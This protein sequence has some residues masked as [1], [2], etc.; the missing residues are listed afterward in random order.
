VVTEAPAVTTYTGAAY[1]LTV[2]YPAGWQQVAGD[3]SPSF[4]GTDGFFTIGG[5][6][7]ADSVDDVCRAQAADSLQPFGTAPTIEALTVDGQE[8]CLIL[9]SADQ[10]AEARGAARLVA[11]LPYELFSVGYNFLVLDADATHIRPIAAS[12][13]F[14]GHD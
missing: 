5:T 12:L 14:L 1:P 2:D 9:P 6:A 10:P 3:P 4:E 8:A 7:S 13:R 11:R